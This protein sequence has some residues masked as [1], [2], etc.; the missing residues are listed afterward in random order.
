MKKTLLSHITS[1]QKIK[2][3]EMELAYY[4]NRDA[5]HEDFDFFLT[6]PLT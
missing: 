3:L 1:N 2:Q 5:L 6:E 4:K